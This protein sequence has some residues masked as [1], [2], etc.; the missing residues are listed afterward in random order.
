MIR[1]HFGVLDSGRKT[2]WNWLLIKICPNP[3]CYHFIKLR[4]ITNIFSSKIFLDSNAIILVERSSRRCCNLIGD[5]SLDFNSLSPT[6]PG[7][8]ACR[9]RVA[10]VRSTLTT[11]DNRPIVL[12]ESCLSPPPALQIWMPISFWKVRA[13]GSAKLSAFG[14]SAFGLLTGFLFFTQ[15]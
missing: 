15:T 8:F 14:Q 4:T 9:T 6:L 12:V 11:R 10:D 2:A 7:S 1:G 5:L 3:S 13:G